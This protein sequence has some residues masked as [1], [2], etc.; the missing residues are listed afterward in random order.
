MLTSAMRKFGR[1]VLGLCVA[2]I[3]SLSLASC[4]PK[5]AAVGDS[6]V[7]SGHV[8]HDSVDK[9]D[10][11]IGL[12]SAGDEQRDRMV[13][14]AFKKVGI[15]AIY[16]PAADGEPNLHP[17][18]SFADM[19]Q[20][21]V[22]AF[23]VAGIDA[24]DQSGEWNRALREARDGGIPVILIDAVHAPEDTLLYAESLRIVTSDDSGQTLGREQST[25]SLEQAV[26]AAVN[27]N[28]HPK[29]MS[30]TLP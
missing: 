13:L 19:K 5:N 4:A 20:R 23:V 14:G 15:K 27:D 10:M 11:L 24:L 29:T 7:V 8:P 1:A 25:M 21:P 16:A 17:A 12:V 3:I 22:T 28:P 9:S 26:H 6:K 18:Q 2:L 30:V